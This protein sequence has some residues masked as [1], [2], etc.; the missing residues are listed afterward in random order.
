MVPGYV[1]ERGCW[2]NL[3]IGG[4]HA[5][6]VLKDICL[7]LGFSAESKK[8]LKENNGYSIA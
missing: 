2:L 8:G 4:Q 5:P 3:L 6:L 1:L 7:L